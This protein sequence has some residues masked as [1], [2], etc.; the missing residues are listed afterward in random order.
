[1]T[2]F[3]RAGHAQQD[4]AGQACRADFSRVCAAIEPGGG[5]ITACVRERFT[6]L[7]AQCRNALLSGATITKACS[8]DYRQK[9]AGVEPG[10]GRS[11]ACM[12]DHFAELAEPCQEALLLAKLQRR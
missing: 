6:E 12:R 10:G 7:S 1:M 11:Q 4:A 2:L 9:C 5:R 8:A 3:P